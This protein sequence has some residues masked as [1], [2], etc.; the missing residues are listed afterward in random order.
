MKATPTDRPEPIIPA[1]RNTGRAAERSAYLATIIVLL[2]VNIALSVILYRVYPANPI[3][4]FVE[5]DD[6]DN[7]IVTIRPGAISTTDREFLIERYLTTYIRNRE[8]IDHAT[9]LRRREWV[10]LFTNEEWF[11]VWS[12]EM[13]PNDK[14]S[15]IGRYASQGQSRE[16]QKITVS[17]IPDAPNTYQ[18]EFVAIDRAGHAEIRRK[19]WLATIIAH[20]QPITGNPQALQT[21]PLG[22][23]V[24]QYTLREASTQ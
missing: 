19:R 20:T 4:S 16:I 22:L 1:S 7:Q 8:T 17:P 12:S 5:F 3:V 14:N 9:D 21:N 11:R 2:S 23:T 13:D 15:P 10:R 6:S 18:A 24:Y